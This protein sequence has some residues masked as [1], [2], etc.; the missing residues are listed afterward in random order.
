MSKTLDVQKIDVVGATLSTPINQLQTIDKITLKMTQHKHKQ[1]LY[2]EKR[3]QTSPSHSFVSHF[4]CLK[5]SY[6][7]VMLP[8]TNLSGPL[9]LKKYISISML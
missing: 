8:N 7:S 3:N 2:K 9:R 5:R 4:T 6:P 1:R